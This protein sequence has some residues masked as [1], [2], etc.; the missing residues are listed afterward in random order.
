MTGKSKNID[1]LIFVEDPGPANFVSPVHGALSNNGKNSII[2]ATGTALKCLADRGIRTE[3]IHANDSTER[4][5]EELAPKILLIGTSENSDSIGL[6]LIETARRKN[7]PT[8]GVIDA[9][10]NAEYRFRG[11]GDD[12]LAYVTDW[13]LVADDWTRDEF[14]RVGASP[15]RTLVCGHPHYDYVLSL[16]RTWTA[17]DREQ[18]RESLLPGLRKHQRVVVFVSEGAERLSRLPSS[19]SL[20]EYT[21]RGRGNCTGRTEIIIEEFL[22][23]VQTLPQRPYLVL[24]LH[25]K[26]RLDDFRAYASDFDHID[27]ASSPLELVF[28]ADLV[29]GMT[30][31]LL[32][33]AALLG[34]QTLSVIPRAVERN[35]LAILRQGVTPCV[36]HRAD[37]V[38]ALADLLRNGSSAPADLCAGVPESSLARTVE[39]VERILAGS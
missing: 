18:M 23:A 7:I 5:L 31:M 10:A 8:V 21:L 13:I 26:D 11:R 19:P 30:S 4:I 17:Q 24:R 25:P 16:L 38:K 27:H 14:L 35:W 6:K 2:L 3:A 12:P 34:R 1:V 20:S 15:D 33:E 39:F 28:C 37:L 29:V 32:M 9:A 22:G 36:M